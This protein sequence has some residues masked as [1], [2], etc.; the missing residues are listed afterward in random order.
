VARKIILSSRDT[1]LGQ[2]GLSN[3]RRLLRRDL[4]GSGSCASVGSGFPVH[5]GLECGSDFESERGGGVGDEPL[6]GGGGLFVLLEGSLRHF[7]V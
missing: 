4:S 2:L 5:G 1:Y 3:E 7:D 6:G